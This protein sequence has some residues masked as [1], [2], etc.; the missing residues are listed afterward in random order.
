MTPNPMGM[1]MILYVYPPLRILPSSFLR[2]CYRT[3]PAPSL[4][5]GTPDTD[6]RLMQ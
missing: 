4:I 6:T 2:L 5:G 1:R 3:L